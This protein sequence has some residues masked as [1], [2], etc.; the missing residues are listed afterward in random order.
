MVNE[1]DKGVNKFRTWII[2]KRQ[3][4]DWSQRELARRSGLS[5]SHIALFESG[6]GSASVKFCEGIA[7]AFG[8]D[9]IDIMR[10]AGLIGYL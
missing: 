7:K 10:L 8:E 1:N 5:T 9:V 6:R 3:E 2:K 4:N